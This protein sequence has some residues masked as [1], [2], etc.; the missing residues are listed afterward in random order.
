MS[1]NL[2]CFGALWKPSIYDVV[3]SIFASPEPWNE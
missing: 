3:I 2:D 1:S